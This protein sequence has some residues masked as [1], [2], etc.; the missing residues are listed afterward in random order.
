MKQLAFLIISST[1]S[2]R[3]IAQNFRHSFWPNQLIFTIIC[4]YIYLSDVP[5]L[6]VCYKVYYNCACRDTV[7]R[8]L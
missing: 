6:T 3:N 5:P 7:N 4:I 8:A 1:P 2:L